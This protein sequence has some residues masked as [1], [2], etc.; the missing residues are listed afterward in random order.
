[1]RNFE[2]ATGAEVEI[3]LNA[4]RFHQQLEIH[5]IAAVAIRRGYGK[6]RGSQTNIQASTGRVEPSDFEIDVRVLRVD[7][8][9]V[10]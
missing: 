2:Q 9:C 1:M 7:C 5:V 6:R 8:G 10:I 4:R 3:V